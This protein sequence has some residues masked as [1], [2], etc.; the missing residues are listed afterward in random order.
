MFFTATVT[1][2]GRQRRPAFQACF[3][4]PPDHSFRRPWRADFERQNTEAPLYP[5]WRSVVPVRL[6]S[7]LPLTGKDLMPCSSLSF[8][9][10]AL[11]RRAPGSGRSRLVSVAT[12][13]LPTP[14]CVKRT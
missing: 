7:L 13:R 12:A 4:L 10:D 5:S 2:E 9:C 11:F 14:A 6:S 8:L 3:G 1:L